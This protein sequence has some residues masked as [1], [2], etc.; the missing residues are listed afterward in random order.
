MGVQ[1]VTSSLN[2]FLRQKYLE[3][4]FIFLVVFPVVYHKE[5]KFF[6]WILGWSTKPLTLFFWWLIFTLARLNFGFFNWISLSFELKCYSGIFIGVLSC[7]KA[8]KRHII[9]PSPL[10]YLCSVRIGVCNWEVFFSLW[11]HHVSIDF[12]FEWFKQWVPNYL[13]EMTVEMKV[14]NGT[15]Q[16]LLG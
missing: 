15:Q 13:F 1:F 3:R 16:S 2:D 4:F 6:F 14:S 12:P 9:T 8:Q 5:S 10:L 7:P 11:F